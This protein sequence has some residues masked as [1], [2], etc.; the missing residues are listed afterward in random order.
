MKVMPCMKSPPASAVRTR[1]K[2]DIIP[3]PSPSPIGPPE[4]ELPAQTHRSTFLKLGKLS[5]IDADHPEPAVAPWSAGVTTSM[6]NDSSAFCPG[7]K[8][9]FVT[10]VAKVAVVADQ[11]VSVNFT[12]ADSVAPSTVLV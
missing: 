3:S 9:L 8:E 4:Q 7:P 1:L 2:D 10:M 5:S 6:P 11:L 12:V